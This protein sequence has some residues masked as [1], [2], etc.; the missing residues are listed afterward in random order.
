MRNRHHV[1][2]VH[3]VKSLQQ[4]LLDSTTNC[5]NCVSSLKLLSAVPRSI[6]SIKH[7]IVVLFHQQMK[8]TTSCWMRTTLPEMGEVSKAFEGLLDQTTK[9]GGWD[10]IGQGCVDVAISLLDF[11]SPF[12]IKM[13]HAV[14]S[15]AK[16]L[17]SVIINV[18]SDPVREILNQ[19][20]K[21]IVYSGGAVQYTDALR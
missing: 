17:L 4:F 8:A 12:K 2:D 21:R 7:P 11:N 1:L 9:Y 18:K 15:C 5:H 13:N 6:P 16:N 14:W 3:D 20:V 10:L 19:L